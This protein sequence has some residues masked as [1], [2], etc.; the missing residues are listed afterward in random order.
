MFFRIYN[1]IID[2][3]YECT[4]MNRNQQKE[5]CYINENNKYLT[6]DFTEEFEK[7]IEYSK[8]V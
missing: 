5:V 7:K 8:S 3:V 2:S 4:N 1:S 6:E